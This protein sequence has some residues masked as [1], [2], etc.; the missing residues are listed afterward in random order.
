MKLLVI[1]LST[2]FLV[3]PY[4]YL[5]AQEVRSLFGVNTTMSAAEFEAE[6]KA[7]GYEC[8]SDSTSQGLLSICVEPSSMTEA[9]APYMA[10]MPRLDPVIGTA[11]G[12]GKLSSANEVSGLLELINLATD[13]FKSLKVAMRFVSP[14]RTSILFSCAVFSSCDHE[15]H[16]IVSALKNTTGFK[17]VSVAP[18]TPTIITDLIAHG[19]SEKPEQ[20]FLDLLGM[21]ETH[22]EFTP[23][24]SPCLYES[25]NQDEV[26]MY[27]GSLLLSLPQEFIRS[28]LLIENKNAMS[29]AMGVRI[30]GDIIILQSNSKRGAVMSFD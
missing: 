5:M 14:S 30:D 25:G 3:Y 26:C 21:A 28:S 1:L 24:L 19:R 17:D 13:A 18:Y 20:K 6:L 4:S 23:S 16:E 2:I 10:I 27:S 8:L 11:I 29:L 15:S 7:R 22:V 9:A 12:N